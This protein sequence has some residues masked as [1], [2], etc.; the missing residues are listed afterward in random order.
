M[1]GSAGAAGAGAAAVPFSPADE[2][3]ALWRMRVTNP[4]LVDDR[5]IHD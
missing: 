1:V 3:A 2:Y 5:L 4:H